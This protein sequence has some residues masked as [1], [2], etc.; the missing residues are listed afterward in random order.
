MQKHDMVH[1]SATDKVVSRCAAKNNFIV[2]DPYKFSTCLPSKYFKHSNFSSF[3]RQLNTYSF[4]KL[5][6]DR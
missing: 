5:D 2:P 1:D 3:V 6:A 4:R